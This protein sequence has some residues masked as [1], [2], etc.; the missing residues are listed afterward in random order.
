MTPTVKLSAVEAE[1]IE[2]SPL[3][4][5]EQ[6]TTFRS[7]TMRCV[8]G[9]GPCGHLCCNQVSCTSDVETESRS[10]DAIET[11]GEVPERSVKKSTAV[12]RVRAK[13]SA[14]GSARGERVG[15][16]HSNTSEHVWSDCAARTTLAQAQLNSAKRDRAQ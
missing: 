11:S 9:A 10:H 6:A 5:G 4:E 1:S 14:L 8:L 3:L 15:W 13:Q 12:P 7:G 2:N 16:R